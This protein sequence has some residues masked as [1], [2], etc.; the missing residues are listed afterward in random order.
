MRWSPGIDSNIPPTTVTLNRAASSETAC[1]NRPSSGS[2]WLWRSSVLAPKSHIPPSGNTTTRAPASA[3]RP[4][5]SV[6][7]SRFAFLFIPAASWAT[8][9]LTSEPLKTPE[10]LP[11]GDRRIERGQLDVRSMHVMLD[12]VFAE[13]LA[14]DVAAGEEV[15]RRSHRVR[16]MRMGSLVRAAC[17]RRFELQGGVHAVQAGRDHGRHGEVRIDVG[18]GQPV[19]D[20]KALAV[21]DNAHRTRAVVVAPRHRCRREHAGHIPLI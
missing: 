18:A 9:I 13:G 3:A 16:H 11:I 17:G 10:S 5:S 4:V 6:I 2:A 1:T 20:V 19:L 21:A 12:H 7:R 15:A 14:S 8:A